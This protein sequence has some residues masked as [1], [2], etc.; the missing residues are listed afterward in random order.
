MAPK[1]TNAGFSF[2]SRALRAPTS[3]PKIVG[4]F[5]NAGT[6]ARSWVISGF[7]KY[8]PWSATAAAMVTTASCTPRIRTAGNP[9]TTPTTTAA[10]IP[11]NPAI[12]HAS[13]GPSTGTRL[14]PR[15]MPSAIM[16]A[17]MKAAM[18]ANDICASEI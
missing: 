7:S 18:P 10:A 14:D 15:P 6:P 11:I 12:G 3:I 2:C 8:M 5:T 1:I 16:R 9:T 13:P 4:S 17:M